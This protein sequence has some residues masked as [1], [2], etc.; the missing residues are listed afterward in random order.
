MINIIL[1]KIKSYV[2][3]TFSFFYLLLNTNSNKIKTKKSSGKT[4]KKY[5]SYSEKLSYSQ[6]KKINDYLKN[7]SRS[8]SSKNK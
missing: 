3:A 1:E 6:K 4:P 5:G 8:K 2:C 7:H